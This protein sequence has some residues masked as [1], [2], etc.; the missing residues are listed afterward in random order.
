MIMD[1]WVLI[2]LM[3]AVEFYRLGLR[4]MAG[5]SSTCSMLYRN[6][7]T[8]IEDLL[9]SILASSALSIKASS[10]LSVSNYKKASFDLHSTS[11]TGYSILASTFD[12]YVY[13]RFSY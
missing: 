2:L 13:R 7:L 11:Y 5:G 8:K 4:S 10:R 9:F 1:Y 6:Y 3:T 12:K